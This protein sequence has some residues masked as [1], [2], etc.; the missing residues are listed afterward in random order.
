MQYD[1][2]IIGA[3]SAGLA[4]ASSLLD[5]NL[6]I[7]VIDKQP[8]A[9]IATPSLDGRE[10]AVSSKSR[11]IL[12]QLDVWQDIPSQEI[13]P[14]RQAQ[15]LNGNSNY[16]LNFDPADAGSES[17]GYLVPNYSMRIAIYNKLAEADSSNIELLTDVGVKNLYHRDNSVIIELDNQD[18]IT[19]R[20]VVV[21]DGK[22]S[23]TR[24]QLGIAS[25]VNS[26]GRS[27]VVA[28]MQVEEPHQNI[29][30]ECFLYDK[31]LAILPLSNNHVSVV[32][33]LNTSKLNSIL[34]L[35]DTDFNEMVTQTSKYKLGKMQLHTERYSY[36][37]V[38]QYAD[39]FY[40]T[41]CALIGDAAVSMHPVSAHGFNF[42]IQGQAR[43]AKLITD[44]VNNGTDFASEKLLQK[45]SRQHITATKPLYLATNALVKLYTNESKVAKIARHG[46]LHLGNIIKPANKFLLKNLTRKNS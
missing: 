5:S 38:M 32:I 16:S 36:P 45:Y 14:I 2:V 17:L 43:L 39:K 19:T 29:A 33:T 18:K 10:I 31:T 20:L 11:N 7:C 41:R 26:I 1:L 3:G 24:S 6:K 15:V 22:F 35:T 46:L 9:N 21:A 8:L 25:N 23:Q 4:L 27:V 13:S 37:L 42:G 30:Y 34:D 44:A 40:N 28:N 12:E